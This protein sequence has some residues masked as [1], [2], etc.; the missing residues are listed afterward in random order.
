MSQGAQKYV[1]YTTEEMNGVEKGGGLKKY[2][3][4]C[5]AF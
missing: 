5:S 4:C 2:M 3:Q 1:Q